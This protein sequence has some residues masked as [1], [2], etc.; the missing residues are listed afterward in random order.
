M[1]AATAYARQYATAKTNQNRK[2]IQKDKWKTNKGK[3]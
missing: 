3:H 2:Q 1:E